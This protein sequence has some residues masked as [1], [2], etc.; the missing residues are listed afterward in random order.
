MP[1][2][3]LSPRV[4]TASDGREIYRHAAYGFSSD[5][6]P[7]H[8]RGGRVLSA[9]KVGK[10]RPALTPRRP[11]S[12]IMHA[13][14]RRRGRRQRMA[15]RARRKKIHVGKGKRSK[16]AENASAADEC[17]QTKHPSHDAGVSGGDCVLQGLAY[18]MNIAQKLL[19]PKLAY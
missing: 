15:S 14:A 19:S 12:G 7:F 3:H 4:Y 1:R 6:L 9:R 5:H 11:L 17:W 13:S 2:K 16:V 10:N 18:G 8:L